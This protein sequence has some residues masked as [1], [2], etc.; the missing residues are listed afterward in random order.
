[1]RFLYSTPLYKHAW[2]SQRMTFE[3]RQYLYQY[4]NVDTVS[5]LLFVTFRCPERI[6]GRSITQ[7]PEA[8]SR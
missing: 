5:R 6:A 1:M 2:F 3:S 8:E 7:S 4:A